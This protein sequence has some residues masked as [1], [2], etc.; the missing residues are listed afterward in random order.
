MDQQLRSF[1][2]ELHRRGRD[3]DASRQDRLERLRNLEPETAA[4]LAVLVRSAKPRRMLE[5][6]T[7]NGY[8][9][10]WLTDAAR[11]V[12]AALVSVEIDPCSRNSLSTWGVIS[13]ASS[14][15]STGLMRE[16]VR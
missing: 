3:Y 15:S 14:M 16:D 9:T 4:L 13:W 12:G 11:A 6:G 7:S 2:F 5:L 8:S 10:A 1:L